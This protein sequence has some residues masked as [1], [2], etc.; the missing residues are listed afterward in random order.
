MITSTPEPRSSG[1]LPRRR[2]QQ[3]WPPNREFRILSI[4]GGGIKG[5]FPASV[6]AEI[7][8]RYLNGGSVADHFDLI[9]GTSTGGIVALG[10]AIGLPAR[11]I[12][13]LYIDRGAEIFPSYPSTW[14]GTLRKRW[15]GARNFVYTR[16]DR[17]ALA[18]LLDETFGVRLL[19]ETKRRLCIP[20]IDGRHGN[21]YIFKTPHHPDDVKD[22]HEKMTTVACATSA[23][24]TYFAPLESGGYRFVDGGLWAN[25]PIMV[26]LVD[27]LA[28]FEVNRH[29]V[30][31]LSLGCGDEPY[32]VSDRMIERGGL[33]S[34]RTAIEAAMAFQ[35][36]NAL[37]Q[38][39]LLVGAERVV[40]IAPATFKPPIRLDD[41]ETAR[42]IL[43]GEAVAAVT[44]EGDVVRRTFFE[45]S[46]ASLRCTEDG[47]H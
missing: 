40:R 5:I 43:P 23:A 14:Y 8:Q 36:E 19:G 11:D 21:V 39:R 20:S 15:D 4:D 46:L 26:G 13:K 28:C 22:Q 37:G 17:N 34:W 41:W 24:P 44:A 45:R 25:N 38:A 42:K 27:A 31:I 30:R 1:A 3:P 33:W 18:E 2:I 35:S 9:T 29:Q 6:L 16:Y 47:N 10:L 12:A 7:E 32:T